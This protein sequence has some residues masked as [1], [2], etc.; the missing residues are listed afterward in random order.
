M[1]RARL[2]GIAFWAAQVGGH[3]V[4]PRGRPAPDAES[5]ALARRHEETLEKKGL[6][7]AALAGRNAL[8]KGSHIVPLVL[9]ELAKRGDVA[10]QRAAALALKKRIIAAEGRA[11]HKAQMKAAVAEGAA[12]VMIPPLDLGSS[13]DPTP[14]LQ[15]RHRYCHSAVDGISVA[16]SQDYYG[17]EHDDPLDGVVFTFKTASTSSPSAGDG[18]TSFGRGVGGSG[19][20]G[21]SGS[22]GG[23]DNGN[24][25]GGLGG[26]VG[27][28]FGRLGGKGEGQ[29]KEEQQQQDDHWGGEGSNRPNHPSRNISELSHFGS[30]AAT[31]AAL[32]ASAN[33]TSS[34]GANLPEPLFSKFGIG[35]IPTTATL[36]IEKDKHSSCMQA[37][38]IASLIHSDRPVSSIWGRHATQVSLAVEALRPN[39]G[40]VLYQLEV[41]TVVEGTRG[42]ANAEFGSKSSLAARALGEGGGGNGRRGD[43]SKK[44]VK[45]Q[46]RDVGCGVVLARLGTDGNV[47]NGP[48]AT[49]V[50]VQDRLE[51]AGGAAAQMVAARVTCPTQNGGEERAW[52]FRTMLTHERVC[53]DAALCVDLIQNMTNASRPLSWI[54]VA[55][56][57]DSLTLPIG[58]GSGS[59]SMNYHPQAGE[60]TVTASFVD[61]SP[62][63]KLIW[64]LVLPAWNWIQQRFFSTGSQ[65]EEEGEEEEEEMDEEMME[66]EEGG[67]G[68]EREQRRGGEG[69]E[70]MDGDEEE[71]D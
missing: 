44:A 59:G 40:D 70:Q 18:F 58:L 17:R 35:G 53:P 34:V 69:E 43:A 2:P 64:M 60:M 8:D 26:G 14:L 38:V 55:A 67:G 71:D 37:E 63:Q 16:P 50:R 49:G 42:D 3:A 62:Q 13:F 5:E 25:G 36:C 52:S 6:I 4:A 1:M 24:G 12:A 47:Q 66:E 19:S 21:S 51:F 32:A 56:R 57:H 30:G 54:S 15:Y 10:A 9:L 61:V 22:S 48:M 33:G 45:I 11:A 27:A 28:W 41:D 29:E 20:S 23:G 31:A 7:A 39:I 65:G 46:H 68:D